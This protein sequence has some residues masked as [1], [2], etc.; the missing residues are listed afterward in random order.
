MQADRST[1][2]S[3][4]THAGVRTV[5]VT[6]DDARMRRFVQR[7]V[8]LRVPDVT[9]VTASDGPDAWRVYAS[10]HPDLVITNL[11]KAGFTGY[12]LIRRIREH[13]TTTRILVI[14]SSSD[15]ESRREAFELGAD[16]YLCEPC[17]SSDLLPAVTAL[18][19]NKQAVER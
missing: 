16:S 17:G 11:M 13:D 4:A 3:C 2:G 10:S 1:P 12:E 8:E 6:D 5:L 15:A 7:M 9:V 18:L 19:P 14:T